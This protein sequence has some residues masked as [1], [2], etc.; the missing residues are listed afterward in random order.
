MDNFT[1]EILD[2]DT[3]YIELETSVGNIVNN[4]EI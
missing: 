1:V 4:I 3:K 2:P